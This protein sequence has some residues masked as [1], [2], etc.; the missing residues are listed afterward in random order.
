MCAMRFFNM[1]RQRG[2]IKLLRRHD[3][4]V[5]SNGSLNMRVTSGVA[6]LGACRCKRLL[7]L[8]DDLGHES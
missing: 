2:A 8:I 1:R 7:H 6:D 5:V 3:Y 4:I